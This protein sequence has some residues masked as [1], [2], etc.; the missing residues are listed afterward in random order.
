VNLYPLIADRIERD[1]SAIDQ[2]LDT[3]ERWHREGYAPAARL[4]GW[5]E[6]LQAARRDRPGLDALLRLLRDDSEP[7]RRMKDF[8]PFAGI[9]TREERRQAF[10]TCVFSH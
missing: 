7:A 6:L 8:G 10:A 5:R 1:P 3:L 9:L 4:A 2:A